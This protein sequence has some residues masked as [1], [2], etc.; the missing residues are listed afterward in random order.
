VTS[1]AAL[2]LVR[3][4]TRYSLGVFF[5]TDGAFSHWYVN[6]ERDVR[7]TSLGVDYVD[8]KLDLVVARDGSVR[9]KDEDE[10][11]QAAEIGLLDADEVRAEAERVL[12]DPPWPTG[13]ESWRPDPAWPR[14]SLPEGWDVV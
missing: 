1:Q 6:L 12:A 8:E 7:R 11:A 10:L 4:G 9:W 5:G 3:P 14:P 13:W 2:F